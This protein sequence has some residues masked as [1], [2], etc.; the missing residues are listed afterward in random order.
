[1]SQPEKGG[2]TVFTELGTGLVPTIHDAVF[3]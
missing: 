2:S 3:W 1:M